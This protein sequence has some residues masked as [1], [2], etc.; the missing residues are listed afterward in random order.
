MLGSL[1]GAQGGLGGLDMGV[2]GICG[3]AVKL[4]L[5]KL[6]L[7]DGNRKKMQQAF[8]MYTHTHRNT[9]KGM[10]DSRHIQLK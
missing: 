1:G 6:V 2:C 10:H 9:T 8:C 3:A 4:D 5:W 7:T